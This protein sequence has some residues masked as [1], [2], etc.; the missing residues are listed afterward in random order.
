M[1]KTPGKSYMLPLDRSNHQ[2]I[3]NGRTPGKV[4]NKTPG[5]VMITKTPGKVPPNTAVRKLPMSAIKSHSFVT[6]SKA[7]KSIFTSVRRTEVL[8]R[9]NLYSDTKTPNHH[10]PKQ[11]MGPIDE[12][13]FS[14]M[15][16]STSTELESPFTI[17]APPP[18]TATNVIRQQQP[19]SFSPLMRQIESTIDNKMKTF[20]TS[21]QNLTSIPNET[22]QITNTGAVPKVVQNDPSNNTIASETIVLD[23]SSF[24]LNDTVR[25]FE[26]P[27]CSTVIRSRVTVIP[28]EN[29]V[30]KEIKK[31]KLTNSMLSRTTVDVFAVPLP[32]K[33]R[34]DH[35]SSSVVNET[36][37]NS[38]YNNS[39]TQC[40]PVR[41]SNRISMMVTQANETILNQSKIRE[42]SPKAVKREP[43]TKIKNEVVGSYFNHKGNASAKKVSK[44]SHKKAILDVINTSSFKELQKLPTIGMKTAY[45]IVAYRSVN[46]KFKKIDDIKNVPMMVGKRWTNFL[47]S[48]MLEPA[49]KN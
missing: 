44:D 22:F 17:P 29:K 26:A 21:M 35:L 3:T 43:R 28:K 16:C 34:I 27:A 8:P 48:N 13:T 42:K 14:L 37:D 41:R 47:T 20:F 6:P 36:T 31:R 32:P 9:T 19:M 12:T 49:K 30:D 33:R 38:F 45:Q 11:S 40:P 4:L 25:T 18:P 46:G 15:N 24:D 10:I 39:V 23:D 7:T 2:N 5:K 1:N